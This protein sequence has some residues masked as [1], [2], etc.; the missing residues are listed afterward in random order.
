MP[1]HHK[2][3]NQPKKK[4]GNW[5]L[6]VPRQPKISLSLSPRSPNGPYFLLKPPTPPYFPS[7][8]HSVIVIFPTFSLL[9]SSTTNHVRT[10]PPQHPQ[11]PLSTPP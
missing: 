6:R 7:F 1:H 4:R 3:H 2:V 5:Q 11:T 10:T 9:I 8:I